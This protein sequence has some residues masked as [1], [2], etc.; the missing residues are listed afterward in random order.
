M[1]ESL[2]NKIKIYTIITNAA[3]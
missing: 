2:Q 3:R 1:N